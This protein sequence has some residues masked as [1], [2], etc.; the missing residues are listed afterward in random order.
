MIEYQR[1]QKEYGNRWN[2]EVGGVVVATY[3]NKVDICVYG[4]RGGSIAVLISDG[5]RT[6]LLNIARAVKQMHLYEWKRIE[7]HERPRVGSTI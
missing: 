4:L 1:E 6:P 7:N 5:R 2:T 3:T